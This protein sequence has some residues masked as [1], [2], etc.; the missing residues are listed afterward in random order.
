MRVSEEIINRFLSGYASEAEKAAVR[1][2]FLAHPQ[3]LE[4]YLTEESWSG[5][6]ATEHL[7]EADSEKM[8]QVIENLTYRRRKGG[9]MLFFRVAAAVVMLLVA[10]A[11]VF[12]LGRQPDREVITA[13][14]A[15]TPMKE[16]VNNTPG[17]MQAALPDGSVADIYPG[18][19]IRYR[20]PFGEQDREV[21]LEGQARFSVKSN[22]GKPFT[23][24]AGNLGTTAL[25]TV[26]RIDARQ[27]KVL[28][29]LVSGKVRVSPFVQN[30]GN[31]MAPVYLQPGEKLY[32]DEARHT[33]S[34]EP[35]PV[36]PVKPL[37]VADAPAPKEPPAVVM[38]QF[39]NEPLAALFKTIE[40]Q[41]GMQVKYEP[42]T[43]DNM[44]FTGG[45]NSEK[46]SLPDFLNTIALLNNVTIRINKHIIYITP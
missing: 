11:G 31:T 46:E 39:E 3:E 44:Y 35:A 43:L 9:A 25:G 24:F 27:G 29:Q 41:Y 2:Y 4:K 45:Y 14:A 10:G 12:W 33:V 32:Y 6:Q 20:Q 26:F 36:K 8:L 16:L 23:V 7:A 21:Y 34:V 30:T 5:F 42:G 37:P 17:I 22:A 40:T 15:P 19:S 18:S 38:L 1:A 13:A 28:V